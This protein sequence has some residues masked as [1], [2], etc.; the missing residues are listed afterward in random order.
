MGLEDHI[1]HGIRRDNNDSLV[2]LT[3][4][5]LI[6]GRLGLLFTGSLPGVSEIG[7]SYVLYCLVRS[8]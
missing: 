3:P 2:K 8:Y 1:E 5:L 4:A 7:R 6:S